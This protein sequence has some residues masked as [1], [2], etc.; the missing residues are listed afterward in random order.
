MT[1]KQFVPSLSSIAIWAI[2]LA[3][4]MG[5]L[6]A[7]SDVSSWLPIFLF[8]AAILTAL[9]PMIG[10]LFLKKRRF[11]IFAPVFIFDITILF[12]FVLPAIDYFSPSSRYPA[13]LLSKALAGVIAFTLF[14]YLGYF[15]IYNSR[16]KAKGE[17][18]IDE[19]SAPK[20]Y[21]NHIIIVAILVFIGLSLFAER[22]MLNA[23]GG[24]SSILRLMRS[25]LAMFEYISGVTLTMIRFA[26]PAFF[27][28]LF[29]AFLHPQKTPWRYILLA[30]LTGV[31][32]VSVGFFTGNRGDFISPLLSLMIFY[33]YR[34][35]RIP[36][37]YALIFMAIAVIFLPLYLVFVRNTNMK[38]EMVGMG[39]T[40]QAGYLL[41]DSFGQGT[42]MEIRSVMD[43]IHG[44]PSIL[45]YQWGKT[46]IALITSFIPRS[47]FPG[48][49]PEA[50]QV[51]NLAFYP[52]RW[53][54]GGGGARVSMPGELYMNF[55]LA[56]M[57][58]GSTFIGWIMRRIYALLS[59]RLDL[60]GLL[61]Y[62]IILPSFYFLLRGNFVG[63]TVHL[64]VDLLP[65]W[66]VLFVALRLA[67]SPSSNENTQLQFSESPI[68]P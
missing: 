39:L 50:A 9:A 66:F 47:I 67:P 64:L 56:G 42:F 57:L 31:L 13:D 53:L 35:R 63:V 44:V 58:L 17:I 14:F 68:G 8:G 28:A 51:F 20:V 49:L 52:E 6:I 24:V 15:V 48:K 55:G 62:A 30:L 45:P 21:N 61:Y 46:Y 40:E 27:L 60:T 10:V 1:R 4:A 32:A 54:R 5:L 59:N 34:K 18:P 29:I 25:R 19:K 22:H 65:T 16:D 12:H 26:R 2:L 7:I 36:L 33:H 43:V 38:A 3:T 41:N 37:S 11:D 23:I